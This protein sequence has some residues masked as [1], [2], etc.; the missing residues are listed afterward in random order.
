MN[1][2][3]FTD[4][5]H[6]MKEQ[7]ERGYSFKDTFGKFISDKRLMQLVKDD[8]SATWRPASSDW[9]D[10]EQQEKEKLNKKIQE[11]F[12]LMKK[13]SKVNRLIGVEFATIC[14]EY[15]EASAMTGAAQ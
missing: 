6:S 15:E 14:N 11:T 9:R 3:R 10:S 2:A 8:V 5:M 13:S 1:R 4:V 12:E 7:R